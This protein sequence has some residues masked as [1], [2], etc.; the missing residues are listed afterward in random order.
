MP[1]QQIH[2][3][4]LQMSHCV[5]RNCLLITLA[6]PLDSWASWTNH[7]LPQDL[8]FLSYKQE[9]QMS[10]L[11]LVPKQTISH[12]K[13]VPEDRLTGEEFGI[14]IRPFL[15]EAAHQPISFAQTFIL[16]GSGSVGSRDIKFFIPPSS[17]LLKLPC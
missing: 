4:K 10:D 11:L 12:R 9:E 1:I 2:D 8:S 7:L 17:I 16:G 15:S 5:G 6:W 14:N 13:Y 3:G